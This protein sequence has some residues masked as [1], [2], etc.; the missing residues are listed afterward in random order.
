MGD[1]KR[2]PCGTMVAKLSSFKI[3]ERI[4][5]EAKIRRHKHSRIQVYEDFSKATVEIWKK[6]WEKV[7]EL[8]AQNKYAILVYD[9]I[10]T[11]D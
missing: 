5:P 10:Y 3:K 6:S 2:S 4:L 1:K 9:K 8:R 11:T 7:K